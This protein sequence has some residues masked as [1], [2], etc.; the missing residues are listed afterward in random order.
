M[1]VM[2]EQ[3]ITGARADICSTQRTKVTDAMT[4]PLNATDSDQTDAF[5]TADLVGNPRRTRGLDAS[6]LDRPVRA[7]TNPMLGNPRRLRRLEPSA[8]L[9]A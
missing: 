9:A 8:F 7:E 6:M 4:A 5:F 3:A 1:C 2:M